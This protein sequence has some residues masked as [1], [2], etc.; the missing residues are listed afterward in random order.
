MTIDDLPAPAARLATLG[1]R[2]SLVDHNVLLDQFRS[3]PESPDNLQD[4]TRVVSILDHHVDERKH[5]GAEPRV[6][7]LIG[8][9]SS[10]VTRQYI[11]GSGEPVPTPLADLLLSAI[12]IDTRMK[13]VADGGKAADVDLKAVETLLPFSSFF[14]TSTTTTAVAASSSESSPMG[15]AALDA[16]KAYN[17][18]LSDAKEDVAHLSG[19]DLLRRDYKEYHESSIR[20]GLSTV[21]LSLSTWLEKFSPPSSSSSSSLDVKQAAVNELLDE[22]RLW[23]DERD[24]AVAGVLTSY[25][26]IKKSGAVGGRRREIL[27]VARGSN[28][29]QAAA[30]AFDSV[31]AGLEKDQVLEL[32][33][34]KAI[35]DYSID[36]GRGESKGGEG[37]ERWQVWQQ[38]NARATRKQVAPTLKELVHQAFGGSPERL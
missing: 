12:A 37:W 32:G 33:E 38:G 30:A 14:A 13:P 8:S 11:V 18:R 2:F 22:V 25:S 5:L 29:E 1:T 24:L 9:C 15:A 28:D 26:H 23:M 20:Y 7:E 3:H 34:W 4:D 16:L 31:F 35:K 17:S 19:H 36:R 6:I 10:L 21:P 27:I